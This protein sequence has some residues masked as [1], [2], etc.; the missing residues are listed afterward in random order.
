MDEDRTIA[1]VARILVGARRVLF[2]TGAGMSADSGLP[3]YRGVGGLYEGQET[4]EGLPIEVMLSGPMFAHDPAA[5]WKYLR[6][7][8][9]A[10]RGAEPNAGHRVIAAVERRSPETVVLTQ[11]VD[12]LHHEA[13]SREVIEIHGS[14]HRLHCTAC[15]WHT[16]VR[17]YAGLP[18]LPTCPKCEA[19]VR[20]DVVLFEEML[21]R[22]AV[23]RLERE[24]ARG[25]D[26]V[27]SVG[28][29]SLF[30]YIAQ[31]VLLARAMGTPTL[32][33][34]PGKTP[35]SEHVDFRLVM[36][37]ASALERIDARLAAALG[38]T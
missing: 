27:A 24:L 3:T 31:P 10:C 21:P 17:D 11:N 20:P 15:T 19:I 1:E 35:V 13:G 9:E 5:T 34:N 2:I 28:T 12:G 14:V 26:F 8:E 33:I 22:G 36:G 29:S 7:I 16:R 38:P 30:P 6:Q 25:F 37:A 4:E 23:A 18:A 32:E